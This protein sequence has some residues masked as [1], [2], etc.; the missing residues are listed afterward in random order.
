MT[1]NPNFIVY[2][3]VI[4]TFNLRGDGDG[5]PVGTMVRW[6]G[7]IKNLPVN[8]EVA[9]GRWAS[10]CAYPSLSPLFEPFNRPS[11][12]RHPI[13]RLKV[14]WHWDWYKEFRFPDCR[15]GTWVGIDP[16]D[17]VISAVITTEDWPPLPG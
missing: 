7:D 15:A 11:R 14:W 12:W 5:T 16:A 17:F 9:D 3:R 4:K 8:W 13:K 10:R 2:H 1:E 6:A